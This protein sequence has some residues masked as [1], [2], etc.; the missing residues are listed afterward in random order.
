[1]YM[2]SRSTADP[3]EN[4]SQVEY[5]CPMHPE[6]RQM[7]PGICPKCGMALEPVTASAEQ[8]DNAGLK[9]MTRR[10]WVS[11]VLTVP[12]LLVGMA[13]FLPGRPL[14]RLASPRVWTW[15]ELIVATPVV[16][17]GGCPFFVPAWQSLVNRSLNMFTLIG[18]GVAV[19]YA[20]SVIAAIAPGIF[21]ASFRDGSGTVAIYF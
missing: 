12:V 5:T 19:A 16:L 8:E 18:L 21:P 6:V 14:E 17:W 13:G 15:F 4:R 20:Y 1:M 7:V 11:L 10:F 9:D 3:A 2:T